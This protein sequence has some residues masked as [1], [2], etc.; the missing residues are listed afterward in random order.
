MVIGANGIGRQAYSQLGGEYR[1]S[2]LVER[3]V[4][5]RGNARAGRSLMGA[6]R[7]HLTSARE[8]R[9]RPRTAAGVL[10]GAFDVE[11]HHLCSTIK[12]VLSVQARRVQFEEQ[13]ECKQITIRDAEA[14]QATS[15]A[16]SKATECPDVPVKTQVL[17]GKTLGVSSG[18]KK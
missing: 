14:R 12:D 1:A 3:R 13:E 8:S 10:C 6:G 15:S 5:V 7:L 17:V 11:Y 16:R 2:C 4:S 9:L 18:R